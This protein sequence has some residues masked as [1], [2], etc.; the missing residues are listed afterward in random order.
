MGER[1]EKFFDFVFENGDFEFARAHRGEVICVGRIES[2]ELC[3][4]ADD[5]LLQKL[6]NFGR[7]GHWVWDLDDVRNV[8]ERAESRM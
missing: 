8:P 3:F 4:A 5:L 2:G 1:V 6:E 7:R